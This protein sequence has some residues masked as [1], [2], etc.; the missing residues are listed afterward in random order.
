MTDS[1]SNTGSSAAA[2][3]AGS[4]GARKR[5]K[6]KVAT[7]SSK[8][9][10]KR[11][12]R[13]ARSTEEGASAGRRGM[14]SSSMLKYAQDN[15]AVR[16]VNTITTGPLKPIF[17]MLVVAAVGAALYFPVRDLYIAYRSQIL[18]E[19]QIAIREAYNETLEAEVEALLSEEGVQDAARKELGMVMEGET[20][21]I[22][23]GLDEDGNPI[24]VTEDADASESD[25]DDADDSEEE[26]TSSTPS[27]TAEVEAAEAAVF[28]NSAWYWQLLDS[29]FF[30][31][32]TGG[33]AV[34]ST[35]E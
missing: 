30:F 23:T 26:S 7:A 22:V 1:L 27:T 9:F 5:A 24:V 17:I 29:F 3:A 28:E 34:V 10:F 15:A 2:G 33:Q 4:S 32:G 21:L 13:R 31:D 18:L 35:G 20:V 25:E 19:Q 8:G 16:A 6:G 11:A 12:K 14:R